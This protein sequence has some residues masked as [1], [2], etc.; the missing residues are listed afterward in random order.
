MFETKA[1]LRRAI[2]YLEDELGKERAINQLRER[3]GLQECCGIICKTCK[4][5]V[6][7]RDG[8][9]STYYIGCDLTAN[10]ESYEK[11]L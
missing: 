10:C 7:Y 6:V 2:K 4:H 9:G 8:Y 3:N 1:S 11:T 5:C